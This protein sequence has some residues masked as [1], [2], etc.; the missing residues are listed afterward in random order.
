MEDDGVG[1]GKFSGDDN[2]GGFV[3]LE[4]LGLVIILGHDQ[5]IFVQR[6]RS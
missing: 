4:R 6:T 1:V 5:T 2:S 3:G